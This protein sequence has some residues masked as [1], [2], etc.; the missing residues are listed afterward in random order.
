MQSYLDKNSLSRTSQIKA[1]V[2]RKGDDDTSDTS[3]I[4]RNFTCLS[5]SETTYSAFFCIDKRRGPRIWVLAR[6]VW[7]SHNYFPTSFV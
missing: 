5:L 2:P 3:I 1:L 4:Q 6:R 7:I